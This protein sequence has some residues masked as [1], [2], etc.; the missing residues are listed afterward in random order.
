MVENDEKKKSKNLELIY[1]I[2]ED[3]EGTK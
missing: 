3:K 1:R 2:K